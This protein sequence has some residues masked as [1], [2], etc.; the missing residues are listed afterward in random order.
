MN[1]T[2][3]LG[4]LEH[5][6][7]CVSIL[8]DSKLGEVY[9]TNKNLH[10]ILSRGFENNEIYVALDSTNQCVGFLWSEINGTFGV[11]PYLHMLTV[12]KQHR[13]KGIGKQMISYFEN[14]IAKSYGK[15]FLMVGDF[16]ERAK[17][18]YE[19]LDYKVIG[20]LPSFYKAGVNEYLMMKE[21]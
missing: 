5:L 16:N 20:V 14:E 15:V 17:K 18:L 4:T 21:K 8:M 9:F 13:Q 7:P 3:K 11:Y 19:N 1:I 12:D 6:N 10:R 2:I